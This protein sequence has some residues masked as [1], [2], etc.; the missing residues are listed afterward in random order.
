MQYLPKE[1]H[2]GAGLFYPIISEEDLE[3]ILKEETVQKVKEKGFEI[4]TPMSSEQ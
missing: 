4:M 3:D 1:M 2:V